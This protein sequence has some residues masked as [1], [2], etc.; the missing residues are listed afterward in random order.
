MDSKNYIENHIK[1]QLG[2]NTKV[3]FEK[4]DYLMPEVNGKY[5]FV[6]SLLY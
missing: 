5:K 6:K 4:K 1:K 3:T 2:L